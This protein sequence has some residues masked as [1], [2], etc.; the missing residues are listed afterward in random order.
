MLGT[1]P[2]EDALRECETWW[3]TEGSR[4]SEATD[5]AG[6]EELFR[7]LAVFTARAVRPAAVPAGVSQG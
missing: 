4:I 2:H 3:E 6:T 5:R 1:L 7:D